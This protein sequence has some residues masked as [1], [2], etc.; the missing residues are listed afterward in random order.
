M[1]VSWVCPNCGMKSSRHWNVKRHIG[2]FHEGF[3]EPVGE[4][5]YIT[6]QITKQLP[7]PTYP[8]I[9]R[10]R[11]LSRNDILT[12]LDK[13]TE[14]ITQKFVESSRQQEIVQI[15]ARVCK[16][17]LNVILIKQLKGS[18][19]L[20]SPEVDHECD[21]GWIL[22]HRLQNERDS[23]LVVKHLKSMLPQVLVTVIKDLSKT[24]TWTLYA[25][26]E[27]RQIAL[28]KA[29]YEPLIRKARETS[30]VELHLLIA[31]GLG[32]IQKVEDKFS[33]H[34]LPLDTEQS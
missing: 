29:S 3:D 14:E 24:N 33:S 10:S 22:R 30:D 6:L 9:A 1:V 28:D 32:E 18:S 7:Y 19:R 13:R 12:V 20:P 5:E 8:A 16:D 27:H 25:I 4:M 26:D 17:C 11:I 2:N 31:C 23:D 15:R 34:Y 21:P